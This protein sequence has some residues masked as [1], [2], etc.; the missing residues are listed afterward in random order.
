MIEKTH[1]LSKTRR[2][3]LLSMPRSSSYYQSKPTPEADLMLMKLIDRI[4]IDKPF[5]GS[6]RIV[7]ALGGML[8]CSV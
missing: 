1:K 3:Q 5:L 4:H 8:E 6:R 2:C 7:D